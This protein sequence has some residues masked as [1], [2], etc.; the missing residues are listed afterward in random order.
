[1]KK[2]LIF[3]SIFFLN[4][5]VLADNI[6]D[7][8]IDGIS[9]GESLLKHTSQNLINSKTKSYYPNNNKYY[10]IEFNSNELKFLETY[11]HIGIHLKKD[12]KKFLVAS[13]KGI[14]PYKKNFEACLD[15]K[16]IIVESIKET[17]SNPK[18][19]KYTNDYDN[20]YGMS[21]AY[22]SDFK[23]KDGFIRIWCTNW[24][25]KIENENGWEDTL[26]VDLSNQVFLDWLNTEAYK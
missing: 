16:K 20:L 7:F 21:K 14:L 1:M 15:Q 10:M 2:V 23:V 24:D 13:I 26:N 25:K 17:L 18:E 19:Q 3:I 22:I 11:S 12:D 4:S 6:K 9:I 8:D 5:S